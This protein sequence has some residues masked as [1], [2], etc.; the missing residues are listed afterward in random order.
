LRK[1]YNRR[2]IYSARPQAGLGWPGI[3]LCCTL[4]IFAE[5]CKTFP[6]KGGMPETVSL[7]PR[8]SKSA[9]ILALYSKGIIRH[10]RGD[11]EGAAELFLQ[12]L[13][14][15]P[16]SAKLCQRLA[17][18]YVDSERISQGVKDLS[19][20]AE[21]TPDSFTLQR[22]LA[23]LLQLE[24]KS[25][26]AE[27]RYRK[28]IALDPGAHEPPLEL[29]VILLAEGRDREAIDVLET[30]GSS[31]D[32]HYEMAALRAGI[33]S[34]L[35]AES[36]D[37]EEAVEHR[38]AAIVALESIPD[39]ESGAFRRQLALIQ[40]YTLNRHFAP[41][42]GIV[43]EMLADENNDALKREI[44]AY[45]VSALIRNEADILVEAIS[46]LSGGYS[47]NAS[48][49]LFFGDLLATINRSD[50]ALE[51]YKAVIE[52]DSAPADAFT[53]A[54]LILLQQDES[55]ARALVNQALEKLP[56]S[57]ELWAIR[58][59]LRISNEAYR[60]AIQDLERAIELLR[61]AEQAHPKTLAIYI[62]WLASA[63]ERIGD[64]ERA[65]EGF[66]ECIEIL[67]DFAEAYNY[68]A[69]MWAEA[70]VNLGRAREMAAKALRLEPENGAYI[71]TM[72]WIDFREGRYRES[73]EKLKRA[74]RLLPDDP[75]ILDHL[76][77]V[78]SALDRDEE[79]MDSWRKALELDPDNEA[80]AEKL[81]GE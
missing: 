29:A 60:D 78:Y 75:T 65:A 8:S 44:A 31:V 9:G 81:A 7:N 5:G 69:Y 35:A 1:Y 36:D 80:V 62:F 32:D 4:L 64:I 39:P 15:D 79:A 38:R 27:Q 18:C 28:A 41:A 68:I 76:G 57:P 46:D 63:Q 20:L 52:K 26:L 49:L 12:A 58:A 74:H 24:G 53:K 56:D 71:D 10:D 33:H 13:E 42:F 19:R 22:W 34:R 17:A 59:R 47:Q 45:T 50:L 61:G 21:T 48:M 43:A 67:P 51:F 54:A 11:L 70:G 30:A 72:A 23:L 14:M 6:D 55:A 2:P 37:R 73:L 25:R 40:L 3:V 66:Q 16:H 77:D